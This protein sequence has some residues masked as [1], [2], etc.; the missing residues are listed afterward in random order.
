MSK[1]NGLVSIWM[2][3]M[4]NASPKSVII[5]PYRAGDE[6]RLGPVV[7]SDYFGAVPADRLKITPEAVLFTML[8]GLQDQ[9]LPGR[10]KAT[11]GSIDFQAGVLTLAH[12]TMPEDPTKAVYMNN[13][14]GVNQPDPFSGDCVNAYN[15]GPPAPGKKGMGAF[16]EMESLSP[17]A[18]LKTG[19]S[20]AHRH[21]TVHI[22][23]SPAVLAELA[24]QTLG[25]D[26]AKVRREMDVP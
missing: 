23:A 24:R 12:F 25:V 21:C 18:V 22:M 16:Y 17:A 7:C 10:A 3:G 1:A 4:F 9:R 15:D 26:L 6:K 5:V 8:T 19:E 2:L 20:L 14:W 11:L 13:R